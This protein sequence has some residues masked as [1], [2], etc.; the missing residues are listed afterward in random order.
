VG[1]PGA[2]RPS[3]YV[4][5]IIA[6][7]ADLMREDDYPSNFETRHSVGIVLQH[8]FGH[9]VGLA[10]ASSIHEVM[11]PNPDDPGVV[12]W[13]PGDLAGLRQ[14]GT[15]GASARLL[16]DSPWAVRGSSRADA[17]IAGMAQP[18]RP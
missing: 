18:R 5:G 7:N 9:V 6:I 1:D 8:E 2:E 10:H 16:H 4:T 17:H 13:G 11:Y 12:D 14:L 3:V 15:A